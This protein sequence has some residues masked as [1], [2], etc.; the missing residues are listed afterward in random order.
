MVVLLLPRR[1]WPNV[2]EDVNEHVHANVQGNVHEN[3]LL[4]MKVYDYT[5]MCTGMSICV[6]NCT[7]ILDNLTGIPTEKG[8]DCNPETTKSRCC[9]RWHRTSKEAG[10]WGGVVFLNSACR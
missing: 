2:H 1:C 3:V 8:I 4:S 7:D 6:D 10:F 5:R 9:H